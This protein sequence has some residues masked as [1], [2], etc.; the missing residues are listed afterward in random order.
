MNKTICSVCMCVCVCVC[1]CMCV[2]VHVHVCV[3]ACVCMCLV[4]VYAWYALVAA[5]NTWKRSCTAGFLC[6]GYRETCRSHHHNTQPPH[7]TLTLP[8]VSSYH[9]P[10]SPSKKKQPR[11]MQPPS[12]TYLVVLSVLCSRGN[13]CA[14]GI[15]T[16]S[17][18]TTADPTR[19]TDPMVVLLLLRL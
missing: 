13:S 11:G 19:S 15:P 5:A 14:L 9:K 2:C 3:C 16:M 18:S 8:C 4:Y 1:M 12:N 6:D 17:K 7:N 10:P